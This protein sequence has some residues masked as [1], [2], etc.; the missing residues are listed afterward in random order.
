MACKALEDDEN[1]VLR[2][3]SVISSTRCFHFVS[4]SVASDSVVGGSW[5]ACGCRLL[6]T[7]VP[8]AC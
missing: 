4:P 1:M 2:H 3:S 8:S 6:A 7:A 5:A